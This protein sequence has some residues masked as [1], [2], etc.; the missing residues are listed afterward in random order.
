MSIRFE[1]RV[2]AASEPLLGGGGEGGGGAGYST[3]LLSLASHSSSQ[4]VSGPLHH[5]ETVSGSTRATSRGSLSEQCAR[6][7][8]DFRWILL[9]VSTYAQMCFV[10]SRLP[11]DEI[12][13]PKEFN[14][15]LIENDYAEVLTE[16][17]EDEPNEEVWFYIWKPAMESDAPPREPPFII[18]ETT[19]MTGEEIRMATDFWILW[20]NASMM[21]RFNRDWSGHEPT[22]TENVRMDQMIRH[23]DDLWLFYTK[24]PSST[25]PFNRL[26]WIMNK[27]WKI[28]EL[29][30]DGTLN[31]STQRIDQMCEVYVS[32]TVPSIRDEVII[33]ILNRTG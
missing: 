13:D 20:F 17:S 15:W 7:F 21:S 26:F 4:R 32:A 11:D 22:H 19:P 28:V 27:K 23:Y 1:T 24:Y 31:W 6:F 25:L 8:R 3:P 18:P 2:M 9:Q 10:M 12:L 14:D 30:E 16:V 29:E 33:S 5:G